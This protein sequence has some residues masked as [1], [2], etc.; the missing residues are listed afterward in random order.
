MSKLSNS[1]NDIREVFR[2]EEE[3]LKADK[4]YII[5]DKRKEEIMMEIDEILKNYKIKIIILIMIEMILMVFYW[6]FV[7]A[8]CHVYKETQLSWLFDSFLSIISRTI[9]EILFSFG[10]A[11]LYTLAIR[12]EIHCLYRFVM[13][14]YNFS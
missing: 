1:T 6:Y 13:F 7:T 4:K 8:F 9:I 11:K 12:G 3:K 2:K 5:I 14:L 10:L